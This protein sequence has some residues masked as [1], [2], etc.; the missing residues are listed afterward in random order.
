M[1]FTEIKN[2]ITKKSNGVKQKGR[3]KKYFIEIFALARRRNIGLL[4]G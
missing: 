2:T 3:E 4:L 1:M